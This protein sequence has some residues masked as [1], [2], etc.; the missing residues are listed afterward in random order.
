MLVYE[1]KTKSPIREVNE[2]DAKMLAWDQIPFQVPQ[3]IDKMVKQ[4]NIEF[5]IDRQ[6]FHLQFFQLVKLVLEHIG[7]NLVMLS[8]SSRI[9]NTAWKE[10]KKDAMKTDFE[11]S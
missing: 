11:K 5:V 4:D 10:L 6:V 3:W 9:D 7:N 8:D 2:E 1:R